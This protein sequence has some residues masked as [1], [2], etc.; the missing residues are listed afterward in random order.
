MHKHYSNSPVSGG[1]SIS[2]RKQNPKIMKKTFFVLILLLNSAML[3]AQ[4]PVAGDMGMTFGVTGLSAI[5]ATT[6][7][8]DMGTL[9]YRYYIQDDLAL[10]GRLNVYLNQ[11]K[12]EFSD[13][14]GFSETDIT[15]ENQF[16]LDL[17]IQKNFG[18]LP[19]LEPYLSLGLRVGTGK[20]GIIE[21]TT[22]NGNGSINLFEVD[23]G[24]TLIFGLISNAGFHYMVA[25]HLGIGA[26]FGYGLVFSRTGE[27]TTTT[28]FTDETGNVTVNTQT[29]GTASSYSLGGTGAEAIIMISVFF[30][31]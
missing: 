24:G 8:G 26:E 20:F 29:T 28:T 31:E 7:F 9:L 1:R 19:R 23:P 5:G 15:K 6:N 16:T 12:T 13:T 21:N 2:F 22:V 10:R 14:T 17:G 18:S 25:D 11:N 30:G 4:K 27:G 3:F